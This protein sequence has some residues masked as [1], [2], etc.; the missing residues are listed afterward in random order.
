MRPFKRLSDDRFAFAGIAILIAVAFADILF[1][2][3]RLYIR[4]V[5]RFF[6]PNFAAL[7]ELIRAGAFPFWTPRFNA[8]QPLAANPAFAALY[9]AQWIAALAGGLQIEIVAHYLL[10]AI[11]M[12]LFLRS[13][14]LR[15]PSSFFGAI[16]FALGGMLLSLSNL[17]TVLFGVAWFPWLAFAI[18][19]RHF[20]LASLVLGT[21]LIIGDQAT[22]LQA[23]FLLLAY[24][25][26]RRDWKPAALILIC[27]LIVGSAQI[28][29]ALDHQLDSGRAGAIPYRIATQWTMPF[30]RPLELAL[31]TLFGSFSDFSFFWAGQRFYGQMAVPWVLSFYS[32]MLVFVLAAAGFVRR[33]R[34]WAFAATYAVFSYA[35]SVVPLLY[36]IGLRSV[37]YPEKFFISSVFVLIVFA[38]ITADQL[39]D[40]ERLRRTARIVALCVFGAALLSFL[41]I[42]SP[43]FAQT[44]HLTGY[45]GDF[46]ARARLGA[47]ITMITAVL[48][49]ILLAARRAPL[50]VFLLFLIADLGLRIRG[51]T[52]RID[53]SYYDPP[54]IAASLR[55]ARLYNDADWRLMLLGTPRIPVEQRAW[56]V[57]NG[58]LPETQALWGIDGVLEN[59]ITL[60]N[61]LPSIEFSHVY[62]SAQFAHRNDLVP[63]LLAMAGT[64]HV[65]GLRD[66]TSPDN[67][68]RIFPLPANRR[69]YFADQIANGPLFQIFR[70][71]YSPHVAF[72]DV[73]P[74]APA[75]GRILEAIER[76]NAIDLDVETSGQALLVISV[77]RHKY[78]KGILDGM[79]SPPHPA[80]E[81]FQCMVIPPGRHH[82]ALRYRNPLVMIFGF[83]SLLAAAALLAA[84]FVAEHRRRRGNV[85]RL[86]AA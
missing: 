2:H 61:L 71:H 9:P 65:A 14:G 18:R 73:K 52:P 19:R 36:L 30:A 53:A 59:D 85:E 67:P 35:V 15:S 60:T 55:G 83:V 77:T 21:I 12:Y 39:F 33:T 8:G 1:F 17:P 46:V 37:R 27:G 63:M 69:F 75:P 51:L 47:V 10:A 70:Q 28:I 4:D 68:I 42:E 13:L 22:I 34:G 23:G 57:R 86:D 31:P 72:T 24:F 41:W 74:F 78:W 79:A 3:R 6:E 82:V 16:S 62:W 45:Y 56:R 50:A 25:V 84:H 20:A 29:P 32:G 38:S 48:L 76:P 5:A 80:N 43:L 66:A 64:T 7:R 81:A 58:L 26:W 11:G 54:P 40:D 44:W 49:A